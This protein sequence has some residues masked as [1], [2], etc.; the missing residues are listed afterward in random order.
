MSGHGEGARRWAA[1]LLL[2]AAAAACGRGAATDVEAGGGEE[3][4]AIVL[5]A[6]EEAALVAK[7]EELAFYDGEDAPTEVGVVLTTPRALQGT[8][9]LG[10][11]PSFPVAEDAEVFLVVMRGEFVGHLA[12]VPE[13]EDIPTGS[14]L[15]FVMDRERLQLVAWGIGEVPI[16]L[17]AFG[18]PSPL[19]VPTPIVLE[20]PTPSA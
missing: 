20:G 4:P 2:V 7:A 11:G 1:L 13:G 6:E 12:K 17:A 5:S 18:T 9:L 15:W 3:A 19:E 16:D 8:P 14:T 10:P